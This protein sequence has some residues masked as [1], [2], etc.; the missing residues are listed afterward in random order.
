M[1]ILSYTVFFVLPLLLQSALL[2]LLLRRRIHNQLPWFVAYT[3]FSLAATLGR[4]AVFKLPGP[5]YAMYWTTEALY[6]VLALLA[7][8][9]VF[10]LMFRHYLRIW[11][12]RPAVATAVLLT[13]TLAVLRSMV[14]PSARDHP[15]T[16]IVLALTFATRLV[17]GMFFL[18]LWLFVRLTGIRWRQNALGICAGFG[19]YATYVLVTTQLRSEFGTKL[20]FLVV[21]GFPVAYIATLLFWLW[22]FSAKPQPQPEGEAVPPLSRDDLDHY[23][24][25]ITA[26][27]KL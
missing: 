13:I 14:P 18:I 24:A 12:F 1:S 25:A 22:F 6:V 21:S 7:L 19:L 15:T 27:R 16:A 8:C 5:Y 20:N 4:L 11:W 17:Q 23:A 3:G 2:W 26:I 9:E 10:H